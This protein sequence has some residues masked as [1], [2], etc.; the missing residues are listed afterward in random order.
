ME[1]RKSVREVAAMN[2]RLRAAGEQ[3]KREREAKSGLKMGVKQHRMLY[4][5]RRNGL[6]LLK[7]C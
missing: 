6:A 7:V 5:A 4:A 3:G 2:G 1:V